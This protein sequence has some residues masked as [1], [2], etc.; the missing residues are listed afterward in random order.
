MPKGRSGLNRPIQISLNM[1]SEDAEAITALLKFAK[2]QDKAEKATRKTTQAL[3]QQKGSGDESTGM[4]DRLQSSAMSF[5]AGMLGAAGARRALRL[6]NDEIRDSIELSKEAAQTQIGVAGAGQLVTGAL[7]GATNEQISIVHAQLRL[8]A[9]ET[10]VP[11]ADVLRAGAAAISA[12]EQNLEIALP[13]VRLA[14]QVSPESPENMRIIAGALGDMF[15]AT[16]IEDPGINL[17]ILRQVGGKA[18]IE[19]LVDQ[20]ATIPKSL[21]AQTT[22][23]A[24]VPEASAFIAW[25]T[26][27][28]IDK[29]GLQS[30]TGATRSVQ[31]MFEFFEKD[32][33]GQRVL[34][35]EGLDFEDLTLD[36][37]ISFLQEP[38]LAK[39]F[40]DTATFRAGII[41]PMKALI[42]TPESPLAQSFR[43]TRE[44]MNQLD[45]SPGAGQRIVAR[46]ELALG[47]DVARLVRAGASAQEQIKMVSA[48]QGRAGGLA[49]ELP[50]TLRDTGTGA[51]GTRFRTAVFQGQQMFGMSAEEAAISALNVRE[52]E[53]RGPRLDPF[54]TG[55]PT[56]FMDI[57]ATALRRISGTAG[58]RDPTVGELELADILASYREEIQHQIDANAENTDRIVAAV[59][60]SGLELSATAAGPPVLA[61]E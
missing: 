36:P 54:G 42:E 56:P 53:L 37:I 35:R 12:T 31:Q 50:G 21:V 32:R 8:I 18:R 13:A 15:K 25:L 5:A 30:V 11:T 41:G 55:L 2:A 24:T 16:G 10:K 22:F 39:Q 52:E 59:E 46:R 60:Q 40:M 44:A 17:G 28:S 23:G 27:A 38:R 58:M 47:E 51:F 4:F 45:F 49:Q 33:R 57:L 26:S 34:A 1:K 43:Q 48:V 9:A 20:A 7:E 6:F 19:Q 29:L 3:R 14:A 61:D